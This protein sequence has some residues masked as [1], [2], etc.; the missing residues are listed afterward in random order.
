MS[1]ERWRP[2][3]QTSVLHST[4]SSSSS[5]LLF[6]FHVFFCPTANFIFNAR[7][8]RC[9]RRL[10]YI[11]TFFL[12]E[13]RRGVF[14][15]CLTFSLSLSH[16]L[17]VPSP[18]TV[19]VHLPLVWLAFY[20][21]SSINSPKTIYVAHSFCIARTNYAAGFPF[22]PKPQLKLKP[23]PIRSRSHSRSPVPVQG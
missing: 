15:F 13:P 1:E 14:A 6:F 18:F 3:L 10:V 23:K 22:S 12:P 8:S 5:S 11:L 9:R 20:F 17:A 16:S 2:R 19:F 7:N 21:R 4:E